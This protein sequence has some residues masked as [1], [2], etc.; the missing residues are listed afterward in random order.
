MLAVA[1]ALDA[2]VVR[3]VLLPALMR[4]GQGVS[5]HLPRRL[6]AILPEVRFSH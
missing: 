4:L 5:W 3:L 6:A 2:F 1:V